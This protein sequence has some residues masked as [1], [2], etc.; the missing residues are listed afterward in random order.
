MIF[1]CSAGGQQGRRDAKY[2]QLQGRSDRGAPVSAQ[3]SRRLLGQPGGHGGEQAEHRRPQ[4]GHQG[5][6]R[7]DR[8]DAGPAETCL[9]VRKRNGHIVLHCNYFNCFTYTDCLTQ[10][11]YHFVQLNISNIPHVTGHYCEKSPL[12][13]FSHSQHYVWTFAGSSSP[14]QPSSRS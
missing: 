8:E 9:Q 13:D 5:E 10:G 1:S 3:Q 11:G 4:Q 12:R 7:A 2:L 6:G 14:A